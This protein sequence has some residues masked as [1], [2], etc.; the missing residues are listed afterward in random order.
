MTTDNPAGPMRTRRVGEDIR[1]PTKPVTRQTNTPRASE[2]PM[3][4]RARRPRRRHSRM[5]FLVLILGIILGGA[6]IQQIFFAQDTVEPLKVITRLPVVKGIR[7]FVGANDGMLKGE[8]VDRI[9]FLLLGQGGI[10]HDGPFLTDTNIVVSL[11]PSNGQVALLSL[12]RDMLVFIPDYGEDRI[13]LANSIGETSDYPG[14]GAALAARV[15]EDTLGIP[16]NYYVRIDFSGFEQFVDELGGV[17]I[18]VDK[19]FTDEEYP[20]GDHE[21]MT[22]HFDA[23]PQ[24]MTGEQA[25][26]YVR[27]RHSPQE[28]G[29]F[30]RAR[31]QQ[32]LIVALK[33]RVL[34]PANLLNPGKLI[35]TFK[36]LSEHIATNAQLWEM[37]ELL[38][39]AKNADFENISFQVLDDSPAGPLYSTT[40]ARGAYVLAPKIADYSEIRFIAKN[41]FTLNDIKREQTELVIQNGTPEEGLAQSTAAILEAFEFDVVGISNAESQNY[42]STVL[43]DLSGGQKSSS[44]MFLEATLQI[45]A[46]TTLPRAGDYGD[47][48]FLIILGSDQLSSF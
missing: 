16:I 48:D 47:A 35:R 4:T 7:D 19:A 21:Y 28:F 27:S 3:R 36:N 22:V 5:F 9:N 2:P 32:K 37:R 45:T 15:V 39:L 41:L 8:S 42:Q 30:S 31:R 23:G 46:Q 10:G 17:E 44:L 40:T 13:N 38:N 33:D 34:T 26:Q 1:V 43:Y 29:D 12:P 20:D 25:L 6:F 24:K 18:D 11:K 14:G